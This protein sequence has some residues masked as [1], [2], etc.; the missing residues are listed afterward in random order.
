MAVGKEVTGAAISLASVF[1]KLV[2]WSSLDEDDNDDDDDDDDAD[3]EFGSH[4]S[5][6]LVDKYQSVCL[7]VVI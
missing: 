6:S 1:P 3:K 2:G 4:Q 5:S 7:F